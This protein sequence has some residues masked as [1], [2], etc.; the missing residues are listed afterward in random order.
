MIT[1][2]MGAIILIGLYTTLLFGYI[3]TSFPVPVVN[4]AEELA[5]K[6]GVNLVV[7]NG[8]TPELTITVKHLSYD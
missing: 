6:P 1:W 8:W 3:V 4:S 7:V 2:L 5:D